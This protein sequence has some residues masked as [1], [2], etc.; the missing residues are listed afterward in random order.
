[1]SMLLG[2]L[3]PRGQVLKK[4]FMNTTPLHC[5]GQSNS[6][7][8]QYLAH[9][10]AFVNKGSKTGDRRMPYAFFCI[11]ECWLSALSAQKAQRCWFLNFRVK[12][13]F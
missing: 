9:T 4:N 11:L 6:L 2:T 12:K 7:H 3:D 10:A 1:M 5:S 8:L 13:A